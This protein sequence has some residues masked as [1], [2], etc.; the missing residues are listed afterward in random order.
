MVSTLQILA[1]Q[2]TAWHGVTRRC[3][4]RRGVAKH[5]AG[6]ESPVGVWSGTASL[7]TAGRGWAGKGAASHT[8]LQKWS[9]EERSGEE[10]RGRARIGTARLHTLHPTGCRSVANN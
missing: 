3:G 7:G 6:E 4:A 9:R 8:L 10:R 1:G 5:T 2:G